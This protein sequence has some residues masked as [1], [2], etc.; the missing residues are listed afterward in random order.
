MEHDYI[1][2]WSCRLF[3]YI[4]ILTV[5]LTNGYHQDPPPS[6][7]CSLSARECN[8]HT[9][10]ACILPTRII[11]GVQCTRKQPPASAA[12]AA[13]QRVRWRRQ[14]SPASRRISRANSCPA[15]R[16]G[17]TAQ[18]RNWRV[19]KRAATAHHTGDSQI[20]SEDGRLGT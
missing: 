18:R 13:R 10:H 4:A 15:R 17:L 2:V 7:I 19:D 3:T 16:L 12:A 11:A 6:V 20:Q 1:H 14:A 9:V 8:V 5:I